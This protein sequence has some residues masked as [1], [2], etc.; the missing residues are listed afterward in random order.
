MVKH[1]ETIWAWQLN[2]HLKLIGH[3]NS[4][5][6]PILRSRLAQPL[7]SQIH[8]I[9]DIH[10]IY[11]IFMMYSWYPWLKSCV[12]PPIFPHFTSFLWVASPP[13]FP[14]YF[15][16]MASSMIAGSIQWCPVMSSCAGG[17]DPLH[18]APWYHLGR[19]QPGG[20]QG[21]IGHGH[22]SRAFFGTFFGNGKMMGK[23]MKKQ[24]KKDSKK[25]VRSH[26]W[27]MF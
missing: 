11:D 26:E 9:H 3:M 4:W 20:I 13:R 7:V 22:R 19:D 17:W 6:T 18:H 25:M 24:W 14:Q 1:A 15:W 16:V 10:D 12:V 5:T 2:G 21:Q 27:M 8:N 23:T